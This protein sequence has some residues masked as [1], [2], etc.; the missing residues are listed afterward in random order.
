M[1]LL[2]FYDQGLCKVYVPMNLGTNKRG[3]VYGIYVI[4]QPWF[5]LKGTMYPAINQ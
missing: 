5:T 4:H 3:T 2:V 1:F